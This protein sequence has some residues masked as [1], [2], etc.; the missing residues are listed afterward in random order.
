MCPDLMRRFAEV[1]DGRSNQGRVHPVAVALALCAAA[2]VAGMCWF[3][4]IAG[5]RPARPSAELSLSEHQSRS[6]G[7]STPMVT[8]SNRTL[9]KKG[10][11]STEA[12]LPPII[13][14][15]T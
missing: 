13:W 15:Q 14:V 7:P 2:V 10:H 11:S 12:G 5:P 3:T 9:A 6:T 4:T 8:H 1:S